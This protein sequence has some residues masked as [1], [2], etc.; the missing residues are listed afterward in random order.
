M[1]KRN[2]KITRKIFIILPLL[3]VGL[4]SSF[5]FV[6]PALASGITPAAVI[7]L[8]NHAR[9]TN[10]LGTLTENTKLSQAAREKAED[11]IK[12]D[13]F[14]HTSPAGLDPWYWVKK[15]GYAYKAAGE[16]LAINYTDATAQESAWMKSKTHRANILNT[17]YRETGVAV[18]EGKINGQ[19][20]IVTVQLFGTPMYAVADQQ[21]TA[22]PPAVKAQVPEIKGVE[23]E[24]A[25]SPSQLVPELTNIS[26]APLAKQVKRLSDTAEQGI[27]SHAEGW[28]EA[29]F[30]VAV[31]L[32][33]ASLF[34]GP[35]ALLFQAYR[36]SFYSL[37]EKGKVE[38]TLVKKAIS[39]TASVAVA[40]SSNVSNQKRVSHAMT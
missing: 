10:G 7:E 6:S 20:S 19:K 13:Y 35:L 33:I 36:L 28:S 18:V 4:V 17:N 31:T 15:A 32:L 38:E 26:V 25:A 34:A 9:I 1:L 24:E 23:S 3:V 12:N 5:T 29:S 27:A 40:V 11:M 21:K 14:A 39:P 16:N 37:R 8:T 30:L 22:V 2:N